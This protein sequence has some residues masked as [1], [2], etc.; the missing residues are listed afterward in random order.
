[1]TQIFVFNNIKLKLKKV[2]ILKIQQI[3]T[4]HSFDRYIRYIDHIKYM[5]IEEYVQGNNAIDI[6][7]FIINHCANCAFEACFCHNYF[8][9][10]RIAD[11]QVA[12]NWRKRIDVVEEIMIAQL[13]S[14]HFK[15]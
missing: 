7:S 10:E 1:M 11:T 8:L 12:A 4:Y 6:E 2:R 15:K 14:K 9:Q 13:Q 5:G 3:E